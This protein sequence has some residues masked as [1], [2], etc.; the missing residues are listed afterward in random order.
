MLSIIAKASEHSP[1]ISRSIAE[2][3][4][5]QKLFQPEVRADGTCEHPVAID[6]ADTVTAKV[7]DGRLHAKAYKILSLSIKQINKTG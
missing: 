5:G 6:R 3:E 2:R 1:A 4:I 7:S